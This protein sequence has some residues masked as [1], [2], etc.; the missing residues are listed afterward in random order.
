VMRMFVTLDEMKNYLRV[1]HTD[2]DELIGHILESAERVCM[3][4]VRTDDS[5]KF[6]E[7]VNARTAVMYTAAY[8]YEHREEADF[9]E[10]ALTLR[11]LL[12]GSRE[13]GF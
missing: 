6:E 10:L 5:A 4:I 9:H 3:D 2:D 12:S 1:D 8:F 7:M 11:N 13:A